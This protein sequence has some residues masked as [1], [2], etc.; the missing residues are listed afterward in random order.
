MDS[1]ASS[2]YARQ[3]LGW[4]PTGLSLLE[5]LDQDHYYRAEVSGALVTR[6]PFAESQDEPGYGVGGGW[7]SGW[8]G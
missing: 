8:M 2:E 7:R 3:V 1:P 6:A 4:E 5:D